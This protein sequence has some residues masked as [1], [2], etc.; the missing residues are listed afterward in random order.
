M[1]VHSNSRDL[2]TI[3]Q[4]DGRLLHV[5]M[6]AGGPSPVIPFSQDRRG[7][8]PA[9]DRDAMDVDEG[10]PTGPAS[11]RTGR[12]RYDRPN[13]HPDVQDGRYGFGNDRDWYDRRDYR[14]ER[15]NRGL[16][17]DSMIGHGG[18]RR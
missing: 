6:K 14:R 13:R 15:E 8:R 4:A 7:E 16:V 5:Y 3:F 17:S 2:T 9:A 12:D 10:I 1:D 11:D 18:Y